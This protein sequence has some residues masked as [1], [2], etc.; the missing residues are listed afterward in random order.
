MPCGRPDTVPDAT[1]MDMS[2]DPSCN[3][4]GQTATYNCTTGTDTLRR[5]FQSDGQWSPAGYVC[6]GRSSSV[7]LSAQDGILALGK[8]HTRFSP[9]LSSRPQFA[10]ET[11]P[12]LVGL[13]TDRSRPQKVEYRLLP[14]ST[15]L[16]L[17]AISAVM[18]WTIHFQKFLKPRSTSAQP[19]CRPDNYDIC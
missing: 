8:A 10:L 15:P 16:F 19:S 2:T 1:L 14:F 13:N 3:C 7:P 5:V 9:P 4:I 17:Q 11:V 12:V 18:L 6:G